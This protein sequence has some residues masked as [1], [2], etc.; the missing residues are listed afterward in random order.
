VYS[1]AILPFTASFRFSDYK[2]SHSIAVSADRWNDDVRLSDIEPRF[3]CVA[4]GKRG[5]D[6][7]PD[8]HWKGPPVAAI[9][10]RSSKPSERD[11]LHCRFFLRSSMINP[12]FELQTR[13]APPWGLFFNNLPQIINNLP[14]INIFEKWCAPL[15]ASYQARS[16]VNS[17]IRSG[18]WPKRRGNPTAGLSSVVGL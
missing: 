4:C 5:A 2:C 12:Q 18:G 8:F 3:T 13:L 1:I 14:Q 11:Y 7:R 16:F 15:G 6:V 9:G 17:P 10:Y